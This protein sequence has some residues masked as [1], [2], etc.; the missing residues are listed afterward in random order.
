MTLVT[1]LQ[2]E[3]AGI[4]KAKEELKLLLSANDVNKA[5]KEEQRLQDQELDRKYARLYAERLDQ[6]EKVHTSKPH[7]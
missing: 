1:L 5:L 2:A 7:V 3:T 6:E 4:A